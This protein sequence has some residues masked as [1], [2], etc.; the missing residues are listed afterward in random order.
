M[1]G[2]EVGALVLAA[3][4][5][6]RMGAPKLTLPLWGQPVIAHTLAGVA[7]A[8]LPALV[9]TGAHVDAVR[10]AIGATPHVHADDH[11]TGLAASLRAGI[12]AVPRHWGAV[13][14]VLG[15]MPL[16]R[17]DT[18]RA[19]AAAL[20]GGAGAVVP[21][22]AGRRG[23]PAGFARRHFPLLA[24]LAGDRGARALIDTLG[25]VEVEVDDPGVLCDLDT[26]A[27]LDA[28]RSIGAGSPAEPGAG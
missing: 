28:I 12:A 7:A 4:A 14:V 6:R 18:L 26:P 8:G 24:G 22:H 25:A 16:T 5:G 27:D 9:V 13:L 3:G 17:P 21:V 1:T 11:A 15:D 10:P 19:L 2:D 23:N 20:R